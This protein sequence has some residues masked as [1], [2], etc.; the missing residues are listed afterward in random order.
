MA[1]HFICGEG[2]IRTH[3]TLLEYT[4]FPVRRLRPLG[5]LS[6]VSRAPSRQ[7]RDF[8]SIGRR[9]RDSNPWY[10]S[11]HLISSQAPST[12]RTALRRETYA[13][14][15]PPVNAEPFRRARK[16]AR[17]TS[18]QASGLDAAA[19]RVAMVEPRVLADAVERRHRAGLRVV[20]AVDHPA[21]A[22]VDEG[23]GAHH[24]GL[25]R[26]VGRHA[27]QAPGA[28][29]RRRGA[30]RQHLRVGGRVFQGLAEVVRP[31][32]LTP[33]ADTSTQ[34]TGTSPTAA[35][36]RTASAS[37]SSIQRWSV[38]RA[39]ASSLIGPV[40]G[41]CCRPPSPRPPT[42]PGRSRGRRESPSPPCGCPPA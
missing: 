35:A 36:A 3:G 31:R 6:L 26:H 30:H 42:A 15:Y 20:A 24:A 22:R 33:S 12:T 25:Q 2:G 8:D 4:A 23:P 37:A 28:Q 41:G 7:H 5:H 18:A 9:A 19:H 39:S 21:D 34:P 14:P 1:G 16:N 10:L 40:R 17:S 29:G 38:A 27:L 11:V 13:K 32:E